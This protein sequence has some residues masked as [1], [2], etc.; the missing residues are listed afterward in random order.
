MPNSVATKSAVEPLV[1][2]RARAQLW[3]TVYRYRWYYV[4]MLPGLLYFL[5]YHYIPMG[6]VII[7]FKDYNLF[8]GVW[9]SPWVG[10]N[11]F[12]EIFTSPDIYRTISNTLIIS[13]YRIVF[14][15]IPDV[16]LAIVLNEIRVRWFKR[17]VQ[18]ITYGPYFL[19]WVIV[20]SLV[21]A[22]LA[23]DSGLVNTFFKNFD[24]QTIDF[25]TVKEYFRTILVS[26]D[27]WKSTGFGAIIY[28]ASLAA[29]DP[30]LYEAAVVDG[31][32]R[33]RQIWHITLPGIR[34]V[35]ILLLV[36]RI[37]HIMD[38][39]FEQV[40]I[41]LNSRVYETGDIIDTWVFRR[42]LEQLQFSI[43]TA[44]G[45]FKGVI[46]LILIIGA[47]RI[48]KRFGGGIW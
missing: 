2:K 14:G 10:F 30:H 42:G 22:F 23:P 34:N 18:T 46:G 7:A 45:L 48:A 44:V 29:I 20:Y 6:G 5:I 38:A 39:G 1:K 27:V 28:L 11:H 32:S 35:F 15:M 26:S 24:L 8:K 3:R 41:F 4:M 16:L 17:T 31:A 21:F 9:S 19:S 43:A 36:L 47:N 13:F 33:W 25:L 40:Y 12:K 37:G